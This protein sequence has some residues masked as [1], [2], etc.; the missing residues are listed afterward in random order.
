MGTSRDWLSERVLFGLLI[1]A[2]YF[3]VVAGTMFIPAANS[4][5]A[6]DALL[7]I[8]PLLGVIVNSI[9]KADKADKDNAASLATL[10]GAVAAALPT[11]TA[12]VEAAPAQVTSP[13]DPTAFGGPRP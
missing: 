2:G 12:A 11:S 7:V 1:I 5:N 3:A 6:K 4:G 8:G 13:A 9:W 10:S